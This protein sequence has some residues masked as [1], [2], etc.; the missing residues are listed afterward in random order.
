MTG[1]VALFP[2]L[3]LLSLCLA[4]V[5]G[6][7]AALW[8]FGLLGFLAGFL[9]PRTGGRGW[10]WGPRRFSSRSRHRVERSGR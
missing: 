5:I 8:V 10:I 7:A 4:I 3:A 9:R 1:W 2:F 6:A